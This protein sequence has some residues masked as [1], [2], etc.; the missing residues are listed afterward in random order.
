MSFWSNPLIA[1]T[2]KGLYCQAGDFYID[3]HRAVDT[4]LIT[5]AHSDHARRGSKKYLC[6]SSGLGLLKSRLG[7]SIQAEGIP[8]QQSFQLGNVKVSF[9]SA[10]HILGSAQVR[11]E[12]G[13]E[14]WVASG[15]YKRDPDPS[16]EPFES[17]PCHTFITEATFGTPKYQW[18]KDSRHG[19]DIFDWWMENAEAGRNS[20]LFGYSLGKAQR[21]LAELAPYAKRPILIHDSVVDLTECYRREGRILAATEK[22]SARVAAGEMAEGELLEGELLLAP[23]SILKDGWI[24]RLGDYRT[25]FASGWMVR[26]SGGS[27]G[28]GSYDHGFVIS[29]HAD[30]NDLNQTIDDCG[31]ERVFVLHR[32]GRLIQHLRKRGLDAHPVSSLTM[33]NYPRLGGL[34][35]RLF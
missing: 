15:D 25:A 23:P 7:K 28:R 17:V 9:H 22:L 34:N 29:D 35:L 8:F 3:P 10:G 6:T 19:K 32:E 11:V 18:K 1:W 21:I 24:D 14:V 4:A 16:C 5:H 31:A 30:W 33:E 20:L 12:C 27:Y 26:S 2:E 13:S